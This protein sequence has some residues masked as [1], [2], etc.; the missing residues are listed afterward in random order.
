MPAT[1]KT[2]GTADEEPVTTRWD[3]DE[4]GAVEVTREPDDDEG[5][6]GE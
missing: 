5:G 2:R 4:G 6:E 1:A 3:S